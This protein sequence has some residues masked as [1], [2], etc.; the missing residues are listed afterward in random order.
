M[1][2]I[3]DLMA[4]A[5]FIAKAPEGFPQP[6]SQWRDCAICGDKF[7]AH[8]HWFFVR[9]MHSNTCVPCGEGEKCIRCKRTGVTL[10]HHNE[11]KPGVM[12][13]HRHCKDCYQKVLAGKAPEIG[14]GDFMV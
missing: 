14:Q 11:A 1:K 5:G 3:K 2:P 7:L 4:E 8:S 10:Y 6:E 9:W 12:R 13:F